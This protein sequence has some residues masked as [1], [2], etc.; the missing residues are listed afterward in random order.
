M[1]E[2]RRKPILGALA[3]ALTYL[4][5]KVGFDLD[6]EL[7]ALIAGAIFTAVVERAY[8]VFGSYERTP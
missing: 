8:P 4:A 3:G 1:L 5:A 7:A 2:N 6:P